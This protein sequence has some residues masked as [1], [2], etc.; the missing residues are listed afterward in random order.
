MTTI[1]TPFGRGRYSASQFSTQ[2]AIIGMIDAAN[3]PADRAAASNHPVAVNKWRL[4]R[5]LTAI[6]ED[7]GLSD[8]SLGVLNA[9]LSFHPETAL[10]LPARPQAAAAGAQSEA[11]SG[12]MIVPEAADGAPCDLVVFPSNRALGA[13]AHGMPE[14]TLRRHLAALVEAGLILRRDSPNG[15]RYARRAPEAGDSAAPAQA[16]GFDLTPLVV[17]AVDFEA[18][19]EARLRSERAVQILRE[20]ITLLRR[21]VAKLIGCGVD[22][23]CPGPWEDWSA[24]LMAMMTPTRRLRQRDLLEAMASALAALRDAIVTHLADHTE[25]S[26]LTGND[27]ESDRHQS[28]SKTDDP[29]D[30]EPS[31]KEEGNAAMDA[32]VDRDGAAPRTVAAPEDPE[33]RLEAKADAIPLGLVMEACPD[34]HDYA[35]SGR[36]RS[37][38]DLIA[39]A[40]LVRPMLG[41]SPDAWREAREA[42][43]ETAAHV[44]IAAILQRSVHSS[45]ARTVPTD[46]QGAGSPSSVVV[47]GSPA[48]RSAGG[49]LRAL[50]DKA[51]AGA[52]SLGP[53][54]MALIGQRLKAKRAGST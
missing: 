34:L 51:R 46:E 41:V 52:F 5:T 21:D 31:S 54:L 33:A 12:A 44:A 53:V 29:H 37:W 45:E 32:S 16:F 43:G 8:R 25:A 28:N 3:P 2:A 47:N 23:D 14:K 49:Y 19:A 38:S 40:A 30:L 22:A 10:S 6:R 7:L 35:P 4:F 36:V 13:R 48:I 39:A 17:R 26:N 24:E 27:S 42:L 20:R 15:K 9:L 1:T 18:M 50:S 11:A